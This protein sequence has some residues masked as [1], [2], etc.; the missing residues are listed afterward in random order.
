MSLTMSATERQEFLAQPR[1]GVVAVERPGRAPV[2]VPVWYGYQ[3]GGEVLLW[4]YPGL[5]EQLIRAAGRFTITVQSDTWPY[6]YVSAE[7]PV[8]AIE[9]PA[10]EEIALAICVRYLGETDGPEFAKAC[11]APD[12]VLFRMRPEH[13]L[14]LDYSPLGETVLD[15]AA[16]L[17]VHPS[18]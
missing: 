4:S 15:A 14:S 6:R 16:A 11:W 10:P 18:A 9:T 8:V 12:Q 7:G 17:C 2:A 13:W 3:P 5:K 1:V